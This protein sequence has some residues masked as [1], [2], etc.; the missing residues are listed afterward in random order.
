MN[1]TMEQISSTAG[2]SRSDTQEMP[3]LL[4]N[5]KFHNNPNKS[6]ALTFPNILVSLG[7]GLL[8]FHPTPGWKISMVSCLQLL[9]LFS[10]ISYKDFHFSIIFVLST[11]EVRF[12][13]SDCVSIM[14]DVRTYSAYTNEHLVF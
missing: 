12:K 10:I 2:S 13:G 9:I 3:R 6:V 1:I 7:Q 4:W 5:R 11:W 14:F 8:T